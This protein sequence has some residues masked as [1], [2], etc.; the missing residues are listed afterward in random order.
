MLRLPAD[1]STAVLAALRAEAIYADCRGSTL[2]LSPGNMTTAAGVER[3]IGIL[4]RSAR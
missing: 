1:R 2:R 3:L 4:A